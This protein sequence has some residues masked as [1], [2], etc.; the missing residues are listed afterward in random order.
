MKT[1]Y[2]KPNKNFRMKLMNG[3]HFCMKFVN[4]TKK[5]NQ[6]YEIKVKWEE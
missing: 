2:V 6:K 3:R 5:I 4:E 1:W